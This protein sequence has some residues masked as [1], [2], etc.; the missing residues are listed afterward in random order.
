MFVEI[1]LIQRTSVYLGY[2]VYGMAIGLFGIIVSTGIGSLFCCRISLLT[3]MRIQLWAATL[4]IY[5]ILLPY[6]FPIL[7]NEFS[8]ANLLVRAGVSLTA[9]VPSGLLMGFGFPTGM[10]IV[11]AIELTSDAMVLGS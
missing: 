11:N 6:W 1:G 8:S 7:I 2:P 9:I 4:G 5:L 10:E 3:G